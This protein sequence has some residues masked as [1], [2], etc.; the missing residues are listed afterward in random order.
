VTA[1]EVA[2]HR[3]AGSQLP[4]LLAGISYYQVTDL[5][6]HERQ[7]GP[8]PLWGRSGRLRPDRLIDLVERSGLTGRGGAGFPTGR[9]MRS[10][11]A[12]PGRAV[13]VANGAEG[14]PASCKDRLL[15][16]RLPHLVL[17]GITL[18]ASAVRATEAYLCVH[19]HETDLLASLEYAVAERDAVGLDPVPIR[20]VGIPGRYPSS[21][22]SA[23]VH[24]LN[25]GPGKPTFSPPRPHERG[26]RGR[27]TLVNNVET[28][29]HLALI[30]RHGDRWFRSIGLHS[31]PGSTL[32]TV[33][34]AVGRPGVYEIALG[35]P[36]GQAVMMAGGPFERLQAVLVG[37]YFGAWLPAEVAWSV[38]MCHAGLKA[39]GGAMG[40]GMVIALPDSSCALAETARVVRYLA[41]ETAGQCGPCVFG[42]PALADA[43]TDLAYIGGRRRAIDQ[44]TRL[45][46]LIE[47]RGAC[48]HPDGATQ[49]VRSALE[50]FEPDARWHDR[51]GPCAGIHRAPLLPVPGVD[52]HWA[53]EDEDWPAYEERALPGH[54]ERWG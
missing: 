30:A 52:D 12:G 37:G 2:P 34:G 46:P 23:I 42:L 16:T 32:V 14:E 13:V 10:V 39:A 4:R 19:R 1:L 36:V 44:I 6:E 9:K 41:D 25:G 51:R 20:L 43:V 54:V 28:L 50:A 48:R 40:A 7:H 33:S 26:V 15:L 47:R 11:A 8:L 18:A 17:D 27:P 29:A 45:L 38:P 49:L 31:A 5:R 22:Q 3:R 53:D 35:T 21:E 24:Y